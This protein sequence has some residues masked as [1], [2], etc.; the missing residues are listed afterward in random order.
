MSQLGHDFKVEVK[1][2]YKEIPLKLCIQVS[3]YETERE[4]EEES[5]QIE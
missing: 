1:A 5:S 3:P 2:N 4:D